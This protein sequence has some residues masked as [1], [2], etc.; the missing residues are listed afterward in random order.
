MEHYSVLL[1]EAISL[2]DVKKDGTYVDLTL[3]RGGHSSK[4][5]EKLEN[6][7]LYS[8]DLDIEAI[9]E[10]R[11]RLEKISKNFTLIHANFAS[12]LE[13][14]QARGVEEVDGII[15]DLGVSSPQ[16][17]DAERGF[18]YRFDGPLDMR[19]NKD[20]SIS[21]KEIVN[22]YSLEELTKIFREYG[23]DKDSYRVAKKIVIERE[24]KEIETTFE[25]VEIIKKAKPYSSLEKKGHPAKQI[26]QALRIETNH[27][28]DNLKKVLS[29]FDKI[30][31]KS[32][33][34][35]IISFHSLEDRLVKE[36]FKELSVTIGSRHELVPSKEIEAP[37]LALTKKAIRPSEDELI[38][39][40]RS[41][42][43]LLRAIM[44]K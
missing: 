40:H 41:N 10:S 7:H 39:N 33:R 6:G 16:F 11:P 23:E 32:G 3:G 34:I 20:A 14:L 36:R 26:F 29:T 8:F 17:D 27:E 35:V 31:K 43:A 21:A 28:L 38:D 5:L 44:K 15:I 19:M 9:N 2:L 18:S 42:S 13:E 24:K 25:L 1:N 37:Y 12:Y 22:T 4:I 30:L